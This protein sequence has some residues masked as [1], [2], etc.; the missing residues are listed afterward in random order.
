MDMQKTKEIIKAQ[1]LVALK[2]HDDLARVI[3]K[4]TKK[5]MGDNQQVELEKEVW[6]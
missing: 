4:E 2:K 1:V 3:K 5:R 6:E